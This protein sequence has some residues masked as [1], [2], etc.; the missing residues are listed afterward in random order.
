VTDIVT[1]A[2]YWRDRPDPYESRV[3]LVDRWVAHD[4]LLDEGM[5]SIPSVSRL[6]SQT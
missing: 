2:A 4:R 5:T 3:F 1:T 6:S